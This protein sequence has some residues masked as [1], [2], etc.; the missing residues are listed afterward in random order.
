MLPGAII[1]FSKK[2]H[3]QFITPYIK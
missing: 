2:P 1:A 3:R